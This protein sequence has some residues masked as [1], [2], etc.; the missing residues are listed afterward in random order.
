MGLT[1]K[2]MGGPGAI[3][4]LVFRLFCRTPVARENEADRLASGVYTA[5]KNFRM[6]RRLVT[7]TSISAGV[8]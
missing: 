8:L 2:F 6:R 3:P 4:V 1:S 7:R 5:P